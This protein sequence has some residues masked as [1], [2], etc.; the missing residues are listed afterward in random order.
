MIRD[1]EPVLHALNKELHDMAQPLASLQCRLE[2]GQMLADAASLVEA[3]NGAL[4]DLD[5]VNTSFSRLRAVLSTSGEDSRT[6]EPRG[7]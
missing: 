5:R 2:L 7:A 1:A 6:F 3:V 4:L